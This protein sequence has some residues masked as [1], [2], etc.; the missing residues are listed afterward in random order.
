M[1]GCGGVAT[2]IPRR[3]VHIP[4]IHN[5]ADLGCAAGQAQSRFSDEEWKAHQ[6]A[7][8]AYWAGVGRCLEEMS[9]DYPR[10][11]LY[12][13]SLVVD[14]EPGRRMVRDLAA[15]GSLD[16]GLTAMLLE[17]G[18]QLMRTEDPGL[19]LKEYQCITGPSPSPEEQAEILRE[20]DRYVARRISTT[21]RQ[22]ET[23]ILIMG[24]L[25]QIRRYL[26]PDIEVVTTTPPARLSSAA[27]Q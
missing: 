24:A 18:A 2:P 13:D 10:V 4:A 20:R 17:K 19:L 6:R 21:L 7:V 23:G 25:H 3:L 27:P 15:K 1:S 12:H 22:G 14:G 5:A 9:I 16:F 8:E 26:P 11:R